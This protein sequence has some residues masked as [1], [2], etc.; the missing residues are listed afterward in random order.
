MHESQLQSW[1]CSAESRN[2]APVRASQATRDFPVPV[3]SGKLYQSRVGQLVS[4]AGIHFNH[5]I[6]RMVRIFGRMIAGE[7][8]SEAQVGRFLSECRS[9]ERSDEAISGAETM[10]ALRLL[11]CNNRSRE[12]HFDERSRGVSP[13]A[14]RKPIK[15]AGMNPAPSLHCASRSLMGQFPCS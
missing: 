11:R 10:T 6:R 1:F 5:N 4:P 13:P 7:D 9:E 3:K 15:R 8:F 12:C 2:G 14:F